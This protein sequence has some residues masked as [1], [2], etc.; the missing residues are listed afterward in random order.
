MPTAGRNGNPIAS[1]GGS[2][3][4]LGMT[5]RDKVAQ[6]RKLHQGPRILVLPN[7]HDVASARIFEEAGFPAVATSSAG[8]AFSLGYPDGQ[9]IS[10]EEMID[11]VRRIARALSIPVT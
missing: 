1:S 11:V 6:F 5:H 3:R 4:N 7:A 8:V 9:R 10:R 2:R